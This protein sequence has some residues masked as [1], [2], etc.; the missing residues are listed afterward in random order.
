[1]S[2]RKVLFVA[3]IEPETE[4]RLGEAWEAI[5]E[6]RGNKVDGQLV[7]LDLQ[8]FTGFFAQAPEGATGEE[9]QRLAGRRDV[10]WR[11]EYLRDLLQVK[12]EDLNNA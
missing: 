5:V 9:L 1:M 7:L 10:Y 6:G 12:P 11:I 3:A 8:N 2:E 4:R